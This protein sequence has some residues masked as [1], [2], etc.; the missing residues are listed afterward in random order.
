MFYLKFNIL[1]FNMY[2]VRKKLTFVVS[3][4]VSD[5]IIVFSKT[6]LNIIGDIMGSMKLIGKNLFVIVNFFVMNNLMYIVN[7]V[8]MGNVCN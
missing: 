4:F 5:V 1:F 6:S 8:V 3:V 7:I 2:C